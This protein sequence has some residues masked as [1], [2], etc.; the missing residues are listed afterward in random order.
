MSK[1]EDFKN[2]INRLRIGR[3]PGTI[4]LIFYAKYYDT[5]TNYNTLTNTNTEANIYTSVPVLLPCANTEANNDTN[6]NTTTINTTTFNISTSTHT[7]TNTD[8]STKST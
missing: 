5:E 1:L 3:L 4:P 2:V 7:N 8:I 6:I